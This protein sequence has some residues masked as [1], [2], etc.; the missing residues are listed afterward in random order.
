M[1]VDLEMSSGAVHT[2]TLGV[3]NAGDEPVHMRAAA[4]D[5]F[6]NEN[7]VPQYVPAGI[8]PSFSCGSWLSLNP[9]EFEVPPRQATPIRLTVA[10][11]PGQPAGGYHCAVT[12]AIAPGPEP[13]PPAAG[14]R[15][16]VRFAT[17]L[18]VVIGDPLPQVEVASL[19]VVPA[20][21]D[22]PVP[23]GTGGK[24][25]WQYLLTLHNTGPTH[26]RVN[27]T[28]ELLDHEG[29]SVSNFKI[30]SQPVLPESQRTFKF[31]FAR[32]LPPG[33][34]H[35]VVTID[36]G[37]KT[38]LQAKKKVRIEPPAPPAVP[39]TTFSPIQYWQYASH[40]SAK[41]LLSSSSNLFTSIWTISPL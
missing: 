23:P 16:L 4:A 27:G 14:L 28:L 15:V 35:L 41:A 12:I 22:A 36:I 20:A 38:L 32:E 5:W 30:G 9:V 25:R 34:Y 24:P 10:T 40:S 1:R 17:T 8:R 2:E 31:T 11:P 21:P 29:R 7:D 18:Y 26:F 13:S 37:L 3:F 6:F 33:D 39:I 19:E